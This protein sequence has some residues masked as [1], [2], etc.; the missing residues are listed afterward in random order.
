MVNCDVINIM[1]N[2]VICDVIER[3]GIPRQQCSGD[4]ARGAWVG[5]GGFGG[6][7]GSSTIKKHNI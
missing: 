2:D 1:H 4:S 5:G 6:G 7:Q 3:P